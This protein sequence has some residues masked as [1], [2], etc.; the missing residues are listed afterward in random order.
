MPG[1]EPKGG[2]IQML[3]HADVKKTNNLEQLSAPI[4]RT[5]KETTEIVGSILEL[6]RKEAQANLKHWHPFTN[7]HGVTS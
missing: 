2:W 7:S 4:Q 5:F 6:P 1:F 3:G